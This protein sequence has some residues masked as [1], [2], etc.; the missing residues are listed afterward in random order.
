[1]GLCHYEF[2]SYTPV[3]RFHYYG[4]RAI[5]I[6]RRNDV[7]ISCNGCL[8]NISRT[9]L[10]PAP[11]LKRYKSELVFFKTKL[12]KMSRN[13]QP[14]Y[15]QTRYLSNERG[16][17]VLDVPRALALISG[18]RGRRD[19]LLIYVL[20]TVFRLLYSSRKSLDTSSHNY[21]ARSSWEKL[22]TLFFVHSASVT[23][24][25]VIEGQF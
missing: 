16:T 1:M 19:R 3:D 12:W 15:I 7:F 18:G 10:Y 22:C 25:T 8:I 11:I 6:C 20:I 4:L 24:S 17:L 9:T 23:S 5:R 14:V 13:C 21:Y 2:Y